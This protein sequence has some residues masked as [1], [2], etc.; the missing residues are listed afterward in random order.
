[1]VEF[2]LGIGCAE[3]IK[4]H[5]PEGIGDLCDGGDGEAGGA[6]DVVEGDG[7]K[8]VAEYPGEGE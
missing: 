8:G 3:G 2:F 4:F 6:A 5:L 7:I 1:M